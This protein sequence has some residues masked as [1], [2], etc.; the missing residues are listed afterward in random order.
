MSGPKELGSWKKLVAWKT[1][2]MTVHCWSI[3]PPGIC[4]GGV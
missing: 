2:I 4:D 3:P 1:D